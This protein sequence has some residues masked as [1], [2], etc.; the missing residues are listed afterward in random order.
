MSGSL[1]QTSL[2]SGEDIQPQ[3]RLLSFLFRNK[4]IPIPTDEERKPY[5]FQDANIINRALFYW[6]TPVMNVGYR[7]TLQPN[8]LFYLPENMKIEYN[9]SLFN[10]NLAAE[11]E[12]SHV[13]HIQKKCRERNETIAT[14]SVSEEE[15]LKDFKMTA[16]NIL[17]ALFVTFRSDVL[18][19]LMFAVISTTA[20]ACSPFVTKSLISYV[21][22]RGLGSDIHAGKGVGLAIGVTVMALTGGTNLAYLQFIMQSCGTKVKSILTSLILEKS[23]ILTAEARHKFPAS[24]I[25]SLMSTDLSRVERAFVLTPHLSTLP[26]P[27]VIS[28]ALL[29]VNIG[30]AGVIG[31]VIFLAFLFAITF[32]T[33][34]L[35]KYRKIVSSMTDER[36]RLIREILNNLKVIKF[37]SWE[38]P[39]LSS[40]VRARSKEI[41]IIMRIQSLRNVVDAVSMSL[42]NVTAM[43]SFLALYGLEGTVRNAAAMFSSVTSFD[44]LSF[45]IYM[46]PLALSTSAD[47]L[48]GLKRIADFLSAPELEVNERYVKISDKTNPNSLE[49]RNAKFDWEVFD[50]EEVAEKPPK[51]SKNI[52][53]RSKKN[54]EESLEKPL[55]KSQSIDNKSFPG[56]L[57]INLIIKKGEFVVITGS[58]G[59]GKSSLLSAIGG[60]MNIEE[61]TIEINGTL[62]NCGAPWILNATIKDNI[63][64]GTPYDKQR[65][66]SVIYACALQNDLDNLEGGDMTE[67]GEKGITLSGGQKARINLARAVYADNDIILMDD[68]LSAVDVNVG[69]HVVNSCLLDLLKDKTRV[70]ATHQLSLIGSADRIIYLNGDGTIE[71]GKRDE[72]SVRCSGFRKL[73]AF[74][75]AEKNDEEEEVIPVEEE[76]DVSDQLIERF[77]GSKSSDPNSQMTQ[78]RNGISVKNI[79]EDAEENYKD[80]TMGKDASKGK[81]IKKE[82]RAVN[83]IKN[84]VYYN[85]IKFGSGKIN[86]YIIAFAIILLLTLAIFSNIF[87]N[88]WLS[89]W[90]SRKFTDK[91]DSFYVGIYILLNLIGV[92]FLTGLFTL[93]ATVTTTSSKNMILLAINKVLH[94]PMSYLDVT[95]MGRILNRF[96]KDTDVLDNEIVENLKSVLYIGGEIVGILILLI[97]YLP[98]FALAIPVIAVIFIAIASYYQASNREIKR[99][100]AVQ[101][102]FVYD[103]FNETL[104][105]MATIKAYGKQKMFIDRQNKYMNS[106][107]EASFLVFATQRWLTVHLEIL[108]DLI[109]FIVSLFCV[110]QVFKIS[111]ATAGLLV[112]YSLSIAGA[113]AQV[114]R[115]FAMF[116]NDMNSTER[117]CHYALKL[118]QEAPY[119]IED[120]K[121][122]SDWP[123]HGGIKFDNVSMNYRPGL[124]LVLKQLAFDVKPGEKIGI[125]GRTGAGKSSIMTVL[126]RICELESGKILIDD[127][128]ISSIGLNDL[129]SKLSIIPQDPVLFNGTIRNNLDPFGENEDDKLWDALRRSGLITKEELKSIEKNVKPDQVNSEDDQKLHKFHLDQIVEEEGA[130]F[131]LGERQLIAFGR[132]LVRD[133]KI[134][135]LDEATSSVDYETDSKIQNTIATEFKDCTILCIAHRLKTIINYDKILTMHRGELAEFDTPWKLFNLEGGIF[136][137]MC[138]KSSIT[139]EDFLHKY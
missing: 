48:N 121:P 132:A 87:S 23:F 89:F 84:E 98:W 128:D 72:L 15:D 54:S 21:E 80:V 55:E 70:L 5:P 2:E 111:P 124:P 25:T 12:Y 41:S 19:T 64:F 83:R 139:A 9:T 51:K 17:F 134:L 35:Y 119:T 75:T 125:C 7:R 27:I 96:T 26:I 88:T 99:L 115:T 42:T 10:E 6:A 33:T 69:K 66:D 18:Y 24:K 11:L 120:K 118:E 32:S 36:V 78:R 90:I 49:I 79:K 114:I 40:V 123:Q 43:I 60:T 13:K 122:K 39:Y 82:E 109:I 116:E 29:V 45:G 61:G 101:R 117:V 100:E 108:A 73:M 76:I 30:V 65:Y 62:T 86:P 77:V 103:N 106:T 129:R 63:L 37:Y 1:E 71:V 130:N 105:G 56:L 138:E 14:S 44:V 107:N 127:V 137:E 133:T 104:T 50:V 59:S 74:S 126:Y 28:I 8:D 91:P 58:I 57:D 20:M 94:T 113:L 102:S 52:L 112:S 131:S 68:V 85:L 38:V 53:K 97:I 93:L 47:L 81:L 67:V 16:F 110:R 22:D 3:K 31:V 95:P 135:I 4:S 34:Q 46:I 92:V 136:Q